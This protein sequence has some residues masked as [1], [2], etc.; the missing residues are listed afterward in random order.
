MCTLQVLEILKQRGEKGALILATSEMGDV[1]AHFGNWGGAV[2][3][4]R[5]ALDTLIGPYQ[6]CVVYCGC[7]LTS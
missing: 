6:V 1:H 7:G 3:A 5:D 2:A 4:W